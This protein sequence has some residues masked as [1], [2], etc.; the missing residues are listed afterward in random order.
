VPA[1]HLSKVLAPS[2]TETRSGVGSRLTHLKST[3]FLHL[4]FLI[5]PLDQDTLSTPVSLHAEACRLRSRTSR[6]LISTVITARDHLTP[7][8]HCCRRQSRY[9]HCSAHHQTLPALAAPVPDNCLGKE[10]LILSSAVILAWRP[11]TQVTQN[12]AGPSSPNRRTQHE[13]RFPSPGTLCSPKTCP[14]PFP[15]P[16]EPVVLLIIPLP[17]DRSCLLT[18]RHL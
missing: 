16:Q 2:K 12:T 18:L 4:L 10:E 5:L 8:G 1:L 6:H 13:T 11:R 3:L 17:R 15:S 9:T 14:L 7:Q